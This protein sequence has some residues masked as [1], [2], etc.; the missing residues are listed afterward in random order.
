LTIFAATATTTNK[1]NP[2]TTNI[3]E[4][5]SSP[6]KV[7]MSTYAPDSESTTSHMMTRH[8]YQAS[9]AAAIETEKSN[10]N[11]N[12]MIHLDDSDQWTTLLNFSSSQDMLEVQLQDFLLNREE[13]EDDE[14]SSSSSASSAFWFPNTKGWVSAGSLLFL[15]VLFVW[16][17]CI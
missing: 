4:S 8:V 15:A 16:V 5:V 1:I 11:Q 6:D 13:N 9:P 10:K 2:A 14:P 17:G 12:L 3:A 7:G